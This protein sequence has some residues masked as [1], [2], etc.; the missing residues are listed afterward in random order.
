MVSRIGN[1]LLICAGICWACP[2][3]AG[4]RKP[5]ESPS[6]TD[7]SDAELRDYYSANGLLNRGLY[8]LA[9]AEYG[10]FL[11]EHSEHAKAPVARYGLAVCL[12]RLERFEEAAA[13][14]ARL[15]G[16]E[17]LPYLPEVLTMQGQ[18]LLSLD[19]PGEA[20]DAFDAVL[21]AHRDHDLAD[22]AVAGATESHY[23]AGHYDEA[24]SRCRLF[25]S[26]W[27]DGPLRERVEFFWG[28]SAMGRK[29]F[30]AAVEHFEHILR[31]YGQG[32][33]AEQA[34]LFLAECCQH[35]GAIERA[36]LHYGEMLKRSGGRFQPDALYGLGLIELGRGQAERAAG[37]FERLIAQHADSP[38]TLA[39][40]FHLARAWFEQDALD[41]AMG[42]F[43]QC[44]EELKGSALEDDAAY[45]IAKCTLRL[46]RQAE[47][48][49]LFGNV[50][51]KFPESDLL[52]E[53]TYDR[54]VAL[55]QAGA[56]AEAVEILAGFRERFSDHAVAAD[57]LY[58]LAV[59]E[60]D[61]ERYDKSRAHCRSFDERH[62][63]HAL[64]PAVTF[65][66]A[67]NDLL[68]GRYAE[69]AEAYRR[70]LSR[71]P[72]DERAAQA[73][74]R[75]GTALYRFEQ[76]DEAAPLLAEAADSA[77]SGERYRTGLLALG[78]IHFRRSEWNQA[79]RRLRAYLEAG[80]EGPG[81]DDAL[82][83][84][85][86]SLQRQGEHAAA[87]ET[88]DR[89]IERYKDS[90]H[91]LQAMFERG[92]ALT[93]MDR[94]DEA[95]KAFERVL[96]DGGDS[97]FK[98]YALNH[99][100][101]LAMRQKDFEKAAEL[102]AHAGEGDA[103]LDPAETM[104]H[105]GQALLAAAQF[106]AAGEVFEAL[107]QQHP[108]HAR[109][110]PACAQLAIAL[111]RQ[112]RHEEALAI[113][114]RAER[115]HAAALDAGTRASLQY[116]MAW[117][118]RKLGRT[119]ESTETLRALLRG[120]APREIE[121]HGLLELAGIE[122]EAKRYQEAAELLWR[123]RQTAGKDGFEL[124]ADV[125]EQATYR[126]AVCEFQLG[127]LS[128]AAELFEEFL[129]LHPQSTL[130]AS[131]GFFCGETLQKLGRHE[132]AAEHLT[133]VVEQHTDD[134]VFGPALLR[135]G[136]TL[137]TLQRWPRAEQLFSAYLDRFGDSEL[138]FQAR[139]G[140]GWARENQGR[141]EDAVREYR[142]VVERHSGS[143]AARAQFQIG[144][145]LFA[146]KKY[147]EAAGE[148]LKVDILYDYPEWSAAALY[149]AGQVF[150]K[151]NQR[152]EARQ[153]FQAVADRFAETR[154]AAMAAKRL[155][156]LTASSLP[157][158]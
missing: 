22:D 63:Q 4:T 8:D 29:E 39:A 32:P 132:R 48:A 64:A 23:R 84:L 108:S 143:T 136:E 2:A 55:T 113:I 86:L 87:V 31:A 117:C 78:D 110:A 13:E 5:T 56:P 142:Q 24:E 58:L 147:T 60:H 15:R 90:P 158:Q 118:L 97:R 76:Y 155:S 85:G 72:E 126:L 144:E 46:G 141:H 3:M 9:V 93:A 67:E 69:A 138:W 130:S 105:R 40:R 43:R 98:P 14:L 104:Y 7:A 16:A 148:L 27:P 12:F 21:R 112:D 81:A 156:D 42:G 6:K 52:A 59:T 119:A 129:A 51:E 82:L 150:D 140:L 124:P 26:R 99:L 120:N 49:E 35:S 149:E 101:S 73:R 91:R 114:D 123:L 109:A 146:Q 38:L 47:A 111:A 116:E 30:E 57:A 79:E 54:A 17:D 137:S 107:L 25:V 50:L 61:L 125:G 122:A 41:R 96:A 154:W 71:Y 28:L 68:A 19:H 44:L 70:F 157:G 10:K 131:A 53:T 133:H 115:E 95:V 37:L 106:K 66:A 62:P 65:L 103:A 100:G 145:C 127:R 153:Q 139:F 134:P 135:L 102:F 1:I 88:Y 20:A 34:S 18:C 33:F 152:A 121:V 75:L 94:P 36:V 11:A 92:Q 151:L 77:G 89:L 80:S 45:W 74:Y 128:E 83:K